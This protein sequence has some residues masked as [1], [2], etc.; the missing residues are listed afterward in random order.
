MIA[1]PSCILLCVVFVVA[2]T[3]YRRAA[4]VEGA[5]LRTTAWSGNFVLHSQEPKAEIQ[6]LFSFVK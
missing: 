5:S 6:Q 3:R 1:Q 2:P 4:I